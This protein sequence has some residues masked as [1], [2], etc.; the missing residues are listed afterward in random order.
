M[1]VLLNN[2]K[3]NITSLS[4]LV[5][6]IVAYSNQILLTS[7]SLQDASHFTR[8]VSEQ[9]FT[10]NNLV[11]GCLAVTTL[12]MAVGLSL[13][14]HISQQGHLMPQLTNCC[15]YHWRCRK[16]CSLLKWNTDTINMINS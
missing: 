3:Q 5:G 7:F 12:C 4:L 1:N 15:A 10:C 9:V 13:S 16:Q 8:I 14:L 6:L 11:C 2:C